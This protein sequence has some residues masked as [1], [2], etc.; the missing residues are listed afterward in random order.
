MH[1]GTAHPIQRTPQAPASRRP[2]FLME[3]LMPLMTTFVPTI[4]AVVPPLNPR[5]SR[6]SPPTQSRRCGSCCSPPNCA[7]GRRTRDRRG[8]GA[9]HERDPAAL[10]AA[11]HPCRALHDAAVGRVADRG[12]EP[13][14]QANEGSLLA[15]HRALGRGRRSADMEHPRRRRGARGRTAQTVR[16]RRRGHRAWRP[17]G[18]KLHRRR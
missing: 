1:A 15:A 2:A 14:R 12:R 3:C 18:W 17:R 9:R 5:R 16:R 4:A 11:N 8:R 10:V 13:G 6:P 7:N